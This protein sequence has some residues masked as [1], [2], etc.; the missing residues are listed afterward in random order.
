MSDSDYLESQPVGTVERE[1]SL[2]QCT[3]ALKA[4]ERNKLII[5]GAL[6]SQLSDSQYITRIIAANNR[7]PTKHLPKS[8]L[9]PLGPENSV[10]AFTPSSQHT[11]D[12]GGQAEYEEHMQAKYAVRFPSESPSPLSRRNTAVN[13][14]TGY[15]LLTVPDCVP[16]TAMETELLEVHRQFVSK[17]IEDLKVEGERRTETQRKEIQN[18]QAQ[19]ESLTAECEWHMEVERALQVEI[20]D[21]QERLSNI[22]YGSGAQL[23]LGGAS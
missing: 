13:I 11:A 9:S 8:A 18:L 19:C 22:N 3:A 14:S 10:I 2:V 6:E 23:M 7:T 20:S 21:L 16:V 17:A 12:I 15:Q 5:E 4:Q 1:L